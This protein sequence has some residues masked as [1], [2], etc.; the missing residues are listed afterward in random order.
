MR[1]TLTIWTATVNGQEKLKR[2][3]PGLRKLADQLVVGIDDTTADASEKVARKFADT[4]L[5]FPHELFVLDG[6]PDRISPLEFS[7]PHCACDWILRVDHDETLGPEWSKERTA[8]LLADRYATNYWIARRWAVPPGDRFIASQ[9]WHPDYQMR[10]FRNLPSLVKFAKRVHEHTTMPAGETRW[11]VD[12]WLVHWDLVWHS[13]E[14]RQAKVDFCAKL[15]PY[16]GADYYLYEG[17]S[18]Q[19][20][21]LDYAWGKPAWPARA[22]LQAD[23][24]ACAIEILETPKV[25]AP[26]QEGHMLVA[27]RNLSRHVYHP[28]SRGIYEP[29]VLISYHWYR[30]ANGR[31]QVYSWDNPR[32]ELGA[33]LSPGESA[34]MYMRIQAPPEPG[35]YRV[36]AD[37]VEE[38][39]A[40]ASYST[41]FPDSAVEVR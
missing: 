7:L 23:P 20:L 26:G 17:Q 1:K 31:G 11:L 9:P 25:L 13:R 21:P 3:L 34:A 29:N 18:Y 8:S 38:H 24:P 2:V 32:H 6:N 39:V 5:H 27:I 37:L 22:D 28:G 35:A 12:E 30:D 33:R 16:T 14:E 19:T 40:W 15:A 41:D 36:Q 10:L 4:V